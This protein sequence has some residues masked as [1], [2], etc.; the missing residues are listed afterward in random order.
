MTG[1]SKNAVKLKKK[2]ND[3]RY[4]YTDSNQNQGN[5]WNSLNINYDFKTNLNGSAFYFYLEEAIFF[6][7]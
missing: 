2:K 6:I 5:H 3:I 1:L 4:V 7:H